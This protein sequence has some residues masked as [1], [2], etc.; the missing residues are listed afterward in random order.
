MVLAELLVRHTRRHMPVRRVAVGSARLPTGGPGHGPL[1][2]GAVVA[3]CLPELEPEQAELVPRLLADARDGLAVPRLA[4]RHRL[5]TDL[6]GLDGSRHRIVREGDRTVLELDR[7]GR[8][9]PQVIGAVMAAAALPSAPRSAALRAIGAA[10]ARPVLP[11]G[12]TVRRLLLGVPGALPLLAPAGSPGGASD[13]WAGVDAER[14]WAM[15]VFGLA[16]AAPL[17]R[18]DVQ[19]RFRRLVRQAHPDHGGARQGAAERLAEL[20]EARAL[21]LAVIASSDAGAAG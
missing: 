14:R 8:P 7:H 1:L 2:L 13:G 10:V 18:D 19:A 3:E 11:P 12:L 9:D 6:H 4:L 15:E 20:S 16:A 21:L 17:G 5:Q